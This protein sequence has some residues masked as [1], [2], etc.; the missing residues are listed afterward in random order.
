MRSDREIQK[1]LSVADEQTMEG[2]TKVPGMTYEDG[3]SAALRW[4]IEDTDDEPMEDE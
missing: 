4:V 3:V 1:Q 2:T